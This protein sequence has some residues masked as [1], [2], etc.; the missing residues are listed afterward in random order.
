[1]GSGG[2]SSKE[3]LVVGFAIAAAGGLAVEVHG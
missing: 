3:G 2:D 1:M